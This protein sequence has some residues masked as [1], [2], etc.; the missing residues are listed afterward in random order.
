[1]YP[2]AEKIGDS[3]ITLPLYPKLSN[4]EVQYVIKVVKEVTTS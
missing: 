2:I 1:M 4:E 3:T